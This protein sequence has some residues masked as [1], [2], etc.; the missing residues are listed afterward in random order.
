M[1]YSNAVIF[2]ILAFSLGLIMIM[3]R[4]RIPAQ[5]RKGMAITAIFMILFAFYII[6]YSFFTLGAS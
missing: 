2:I 3:N 1:D 5:L 4:D 6:V